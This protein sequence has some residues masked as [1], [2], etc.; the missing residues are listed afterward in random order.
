M[1]SR[2]Y[3]KSKM[4]ALV[5]DIKTLKA[6]YSFHELSSTHSVEVIPNEIY[7]S[8]D[9]LKAWELN[10]IIGFI[11]K[12]PNESLCILT[13]DAILP[14]GHIEFSILG[15]DFKE[16]SDN[17]SANQELVSL[18]FDNQFYDTLKEI[19]VTHSPVILEQMSYNQKI[20]DVNTLPS[21]YNI[22][23]NIIIEKASSFK[24]F[25]N[26]NLDCENIYTLAA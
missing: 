22:L 5:K 3:I 18:V 16:A 24:E 23:E 7:H 12:F 10:F 19:F 20:I 8:N 11:Q 4:S 1:T 2:E 6:S 25:E 14:I 21:A 13:D 15:K 9:V 17:Y 26:E